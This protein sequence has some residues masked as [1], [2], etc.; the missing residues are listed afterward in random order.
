M[1]FGLLQAKV[2]LAILLKN[3]EFS[4]NAK[5]KTPLNFVSKMLILTNDSGIWVNAKK[6][7]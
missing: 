2:G 4:L 1:R 7:E 3:F 6:I 5:T